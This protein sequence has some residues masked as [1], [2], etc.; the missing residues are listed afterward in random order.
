MYN[1]LINLQDYLDFPE[2]A[3]YFGDLADMF[4]G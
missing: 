4:Y 3:D 2:P 1:A